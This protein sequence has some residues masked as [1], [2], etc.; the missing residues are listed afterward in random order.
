[1]LQDA[2]ALLVEFPDSAVT[3]LHQVF[4]QG[5]E[6]KEDSLAM[7]AVRKLANYYYSAGFYNLSIEYG[8]QELKILDQNPEFLAPGLQAMSKISK[9]NN[10]AEA[11]YAMRQNE[12]ALQYFRQALALLDEREPPG[13][14]PGQP[15]YRPVILYNMGSLFLLQ[16]SPDSAMTY[17]RLA[18]EASGD[19]PDSLL[20][21][22]LLSNYGVIYKERGELDSA[23]LNYQQA[24]QIRL[25]LRD[26]G[27]IASSYNNIADAFRL[28]GNF[29]EA[30]MNAAEAISHA[31]KVYANRSLIAAYDLLSDIAMEEGDLAK[32]LYYKEKKII[33]NDSVFSADKQQEIT[34][35]ATAYQMEFAARSAQLEHNM[36]ITRVRNSRIVFILMTGFFVM[37]A[38]VLALLFALQRGRSKRLRLIKEKIELQH[39]ILSSEKDV[40]QQN[41]DY[42]NRMLTADMMYVAQQNRYIEKLLDRCGKMESME[43][44]EDSGELRQLVNEFQANRNKNFWNEFEVRFGEVHQDFYSKLHEK[45][46]DLTPAERRLA[47]FMK[48]NLTSKE[49]SAITHQTT[50]SVKVTR[51]RLRKK[52][53]MQADENLIG[54]LQG[55]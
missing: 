36:E 35:H 25:L 30:V 15:G 8:F 37:L 49:I 5:L 31:E 40:L 7:A 12:L 44:H 27:M 28:K 33:L 43:E 41:L 34:R 3:I 55:L 22:G 32:T 18:E 13:M 19:P 9:L 45:F 50:D 20:L 10:I 51:S 14:G 16:K 1:M 38:V 29:R 48:L 2:Q 53:G 47:A 6:Q 42:K 17:F 23:L 54:F 39:A 46:P 11:Y 24:L 26:D 21:A 4:H 52:L